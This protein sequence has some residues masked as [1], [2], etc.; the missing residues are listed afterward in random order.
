MS[1]RSSVVIVTRN[2]LALLRR[3]VDAVRQDPATAEVVVVDDRSGDGS[4]DWLAGQAGGSPPLR[5]LRRE[6]VGPA[7]AR[8]AGVEAASGELVVLLDDDVLPRPGLISRHAALLR[9]DRG[10]VVVGYCPVS[11]PRRR[12]ADAVALFAYARDYEGRCERYERGDAPVLHNLWGG[13]IGLWR[14]AALR[15][16][17][18]SPAFDGVP[19]FY[20]DRDFGLRALRAGLAAVFDRSLAADH[21]HR[22]TTQAALADATRRGAGAVRLH[23][24]HGDLIG[25]YRLDSVLAGLPRPAEACVRAA[26]RARAE[27]AVLAA[28]QGMIDAAGGA[29]RWAAQDAAFKLARRVREQRG[30]IAAL[31][32]AAP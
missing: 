32:E 15:V 2:R 5:F 14:D 18:H 27:Q 31:A 28:T 20:E 12:T 4:A 9:G 1:P 11:L 6:G 16:R 21:H 24:A 3:V 19:V 25:P 29:G 13:N 17:L 7:A 26:R 23:A 10:R 22:R 30:A 8:Q